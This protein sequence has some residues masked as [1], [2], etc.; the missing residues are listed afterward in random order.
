MPPMRL[1]LDI[2]SSSVKAALARS[3]KLSHIG[4]A[5]F[6]TRTHGVEVE[7]DPRKLMAA[8]HKAVAV[9]P[10]ADRRRVTS[11]AFGVMSPV[12]ALMD[13]KGKLLTPLI[14]HQDRR[15]VAEAAQLAKDFGLERYRRICGNVPVPG[16]MSVTT[17]LHLVQHNRTLQDKV[18]TYGHLS[19]Y[20]LHH[21]TGTAAIDPSNASFTGVYRT[22][23]ARGGWEPDMLD[24]AKLKPSQMPAVIDGA[25]IAAKLS[26][27]G[28]R[29]LGI[30]SGVPVFPGLVDTSAAILL[31]P[32][33]AGHLTHSMGSTDVLAVLADKPKVGDGHLTR[34]L[35]VHTRPGD[36][37]PKWLHVSVMPAAG[38]SLT[39]AHQTFF[40]DKSE[41]AFYAHLKKRTAEVA[42]TLDAEK[43]SPARPGT[44]KFEPQL[45]GSRTA[46]LQP[47]A[48]FTGLT[49]ATT[50]DDLLRAVIRSLAHAL[51]QRLT[52]L[53]AA[54]G[55][56]F[57]GPA[58]ITGGAA[59]GMSTLISHVWPP[60]LARHA[61]SDATLQG[62]AIL[63]L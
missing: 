20:L 59:Q 54:S 28:S 46:V 34:L 21:W 62:L 57:H 43:T 53:T 48:A 13:R 55:S 42:A 40:S 16:G 6:P 15:S 14:T 60:G 35:G 3:G 58:L 61:I 9:L 41:S 8:I 7:V 29:H 30:P 50:R 24:Y 18:A 5:G 12:L 26:A 2:G 19:T 25:A 22:T 44:V 11:I 17:Y 49:L 38:S 45:A 52:A 47:T 32:Q 4:H 63:D 23:A 51:P 37:G 56:K 33:K 10:A 27:A 39:W 36:T 31:L 1:V